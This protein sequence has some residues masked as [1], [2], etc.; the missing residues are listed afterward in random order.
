VPKGP[1]VIAFLNEKFPEKGKK[2][3]FFG[4]FLPFFDPKKT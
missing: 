1:K 3:A 2:T 4:P